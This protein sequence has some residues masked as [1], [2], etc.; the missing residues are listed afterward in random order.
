MR[1]LW[2]ECD[3]ELAF[4]LLR[5]S[6][7]RGYATEAASAVLSAARAAGRPRLAADV[8]DWNAPSR[9][10][11]AKLG[12]VEVGRTVDEDGVSITATIEL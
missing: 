1:A 5:R 8:W 6:W 11:L 4:E 7:G 12:F 3:P 2:E 9:R 10:V